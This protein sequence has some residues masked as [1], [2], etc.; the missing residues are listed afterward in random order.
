MIRA[1]IEAGKMGPRLPSIM[2][3]AQLFDISPRTLQA[4][5]SILKEE[6]LIY[7]VPGRGTF[8]TGSGD[9]A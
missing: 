3:L 2:E 7:G 9:P 4:A 1:Q 5:L 6:G 8:V